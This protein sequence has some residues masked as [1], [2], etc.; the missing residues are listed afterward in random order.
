M[1]SALGLDS[2]YQVTILFLFP[3]EAVL[4]WHS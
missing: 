1:V 2:R 4:G 3:F